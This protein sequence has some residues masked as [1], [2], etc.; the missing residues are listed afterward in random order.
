M[1]KTNT[2]EVFEKAPVPKAVLKNAIPA[3][4]AMLMVL[5]YNLADTFFIG[6]THNDILVA[7]V[8]LATP[9]FLI[10]MAVGTVFG[11][12]GTSVISRAFGQGRQEY[13]KKVCAFCLWSCMAVGFVMSAG[14]LLFMEQ[15]LTLIGA[16]ADTWEPAKTY[17]TIVALG[18]P[19]VLI[20]NC[21]S[22][23]LRAEGQPNKAMV[24]QVLGNLL[25]VVLDPLMILTFRW[26]IAGA[27]I[28]T[29]IGNGV[30]AGYYILYYLR[31]QSNLSIHIRD[32]SVKDKICANVL[33]IGIPASLGS[34]LMSVSQIVV[35]ARMAGYS[36][37]A[38][39][40]MGVAM[41]VT[42]ITG[43]V[44]IGFGQGVQPLLGYCVGAKLWE[45]FKKIMRFSVLFALALSTVMTG[46]CYLLRNSVIRLFL[47][48]TAS[49]D[50]AITFTNILLTTS[51][52]FGVFYVLTNA[53][54]AMG[55]A[56]QALIINLSRQGIIYIPALFIL[57]SALE[58]NGLAWAQPVADLL[59][60]VLVA[61]L[62]L[63]TSRKRMAEPEPFGEK[64]LIS[65]GFF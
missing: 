61:V 30:G 43:M 3:M 57:Q 47:T 62:Y 63:W 6:Q 39:A 16:S 31:G 46:L 60:T 17:L 41:K 35:N 7:A 33:A 36:D 37:M 59:S 22:N 48:D 49:F 26:G 1:I 53:L 8:S 52:L 51:F 25:N 24:G 20:S 23:I 44:C 29:V 12:G 10:F 34:L 42:M 45:R 38:V 11:I 54:Q 50:Y 13:A 14:F 64:N 9:V 56:V 4:A 40:G 58:A 5:I 32:F 19:F 55:A 27:A 15:I 28:A 21:Y 65:V 18:G 2:M